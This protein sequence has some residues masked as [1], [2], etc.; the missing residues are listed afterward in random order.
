MS[1][2][3]VEAI[4]WRKAS[5]SDGNDTCVELANTLDALRDSKNPGGPMIRGDVRQ[6][7]RAVRMA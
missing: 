2:R 6:L 3:P 5:R 1:A 7:L 4:R